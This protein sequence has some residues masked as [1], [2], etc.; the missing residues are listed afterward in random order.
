MK[1][2]GYQLDLINEREQPID[3]RRS[4]MLLGLLLSLS[5]SFFFCEKARVSSHLD[6]W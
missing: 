4:S 2:L 3:D 5:F 6:P 1:K